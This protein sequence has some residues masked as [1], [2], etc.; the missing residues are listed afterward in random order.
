MDFILY[1]SLKDK[2]RN[3]H[4]SLTIAPTLDCNFRCIYCYEKNSVKHSSMSE[5]TQNKL[6]EFCSKQM[7]TIKYLSISWY[8][9]EPLLAL[10]V[11]ESL[12]NKLIELCK[13]NNI[14][15]NASIV[16]NGYLLTPEAY[17]KLISCKVSSMQITVDGNEDEHNKR[18]PLIG[19]KPT[20][21]TI[22]NNLCYIKDC[23]TD[24]KINISLRVNVDRKN[25]EDIKKLITV[26]YERKLNDFLNIYIAK[27][28]N[29]NDSFNND[30]CYCT[31]E[32]S[33]LEYNFNVEN[34]NYNFYPN[35]KSNVCGADRDNSFV[36]NSNGDIYKCWEDIGMEEYKIGNINNN[37]M[38]NQDI[39][40]NYI[41]YDVTK[42]KDCSVCKYLPLCMGGCPRERVQS[43]ADRCINIKY[44]LEK[45]II[46]TSL[47]IISNRQNAVK[48]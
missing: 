14:T 16:T 17:E 26:F 28:R 12:S 1:R 39:L 25:T 48:N 27:V 3:D 23:E 42:D 38:M 37:E 18:R 15:Y 34:N 9:G 11:I 10:D 45:G 32:F 22:I 46:N 47:N 40:C 4:L 13:E 33:E 7:S 29:I 21:K 30:L 5:M 19:G 35:V 44:T 41:L 31:E 6:I 43:S 20:F 8:G 2:Y 24:K 36:I